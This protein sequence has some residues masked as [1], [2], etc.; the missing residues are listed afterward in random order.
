MAS[1]VSD[2]QSNN[3]SLDRNIL[4]PEISSVQP[5]LGQLPGRAGNGG[6][7]ADDPCSQHEHSASEL[8][9]CGGAA[10]FEEGKSSNPFD[11]NK[12]HSRNTALQT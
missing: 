8:A 10:G 2:S 1:R 3:A 11:S 9:R 5:F 12:I 7:C 6:W 4:I